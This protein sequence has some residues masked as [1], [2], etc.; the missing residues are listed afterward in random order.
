MKAKH[1]LEEWKYSSVLEEDEA[2][3]DTQKTEKLTAQKKQLAVVL[4][5]LLEEAQAKL[6]EYY[7]TDEALSDD[8]FL[9]PEKPYLATATIYS[10]L[11]DHPEFSGAGSAETSRG[12]E[13]EEAAPKETAPE[14]GGTETEEA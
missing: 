6:E 9:D 13:S 5:T 2:S 11:D 14:E 7:A 4:K 3:K 1:I 8:E 10:V 12:G